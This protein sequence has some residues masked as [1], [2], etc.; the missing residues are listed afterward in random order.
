MLKHF[1]QF[2][3]YFTLENYLKERQNAANCK[4]NKN[5]Y[6]RFNQLIEE[7]L[8]IAELVES[9]SNNDTLQTQDMIRRYTPTGIGGSFSAKV[10]VGTPS[11]GGW[12]TQQ[13][14]Y[15]DLPCIGHDKQGLT[16]LI[17][18]ETYHLVQNQFMPAKPKNLLERFIYEMLQEGSAM[19]V[20]NMEDVTSPGSYTE[21]NIRQIRKNKSRQPLN[22]SLFNMLTLSLLDE[23]SE[24]NWNTVYN[25]G[26]S[27]SF[28]AP[29]YSIGS[30]VFDSVTKD[31]GTNKILCWLEHQPMQVMRYFLNSDYANAQKIHL[32][33]RVSDLFTMQEI[34]VCRGINS[35]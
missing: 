28:D 15:V 17:A 22:W 16:Y 18:H 21:L 24:S 3:D 20:A 34:E 9:I 23:D 26:F 10:M 5:N 12:S 4:H 25:I 31:I 29:M 13:S 27:G 32:D 6:F 8:S 30:I 1:S 33:Q 7:R 35:I 14:F 19:V 11:C 2:R